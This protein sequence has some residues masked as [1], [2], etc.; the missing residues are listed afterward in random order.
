M[1]ELTQERNRTNAGIVTNAL[2][3]HHIASNMNEPTQE[4][5][6]TNAGIVKS[7]LVGYQ[8]ARNMKEDMLEAVIL[9]A[10]SMISAFSCKDTI[11]SHRQ[12]TVAKSLV[13]CSLR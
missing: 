1:N 8:I 9:E 2:T 6:H 12:L 13:C 5:S 4:R 10:S 11:R 3:S 7:A